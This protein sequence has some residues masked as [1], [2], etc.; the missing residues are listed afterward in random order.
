MAILTINLNSDEKLVA[1]IPRN[2]ELEL[3]KTIAIA[4][5][6]V[7]DDERDCTLCIDEHSFKLSYYL[8]EYIYSHYQH[9]F[10]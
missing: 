3:W 2:R 9:Y 8:S 6:S 1:D 4:L 7:V 5:N 10:L